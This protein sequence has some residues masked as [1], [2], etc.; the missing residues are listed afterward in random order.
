MS[1]SRSLRSMRSSRCC[2]LLA[3]VLTFVV[4]PHAWSAERQVSFE[5]A[6]HLAVERAPMLRARESQIAATKE[7]AARAAALPDPK[8][9]FGVANLPVTGAD[10]LDLSADFMTMK[11][12]GVMQEFPARAKRRARQ[13]V[14]D[15]VVAQAQALSVVEQLAVRQAVSQAWITL[16]AA[17][18]EVRALQA[19]KGPT[20]AAVRSAKARLAGGTGTAVEAMATQNAALE[21][22]DR[23]DAAEATREAARAGLALWLGE[24]PLSLDLAGSPPELMTLSVDAATLLSS[25]DR[26]APLRLWSAREA[27]AEAEVSSAIAEKRPDW[28]LGVNYGQ[29]GRSPEGAS[30]SDMVMIEFSID[31]PLFAR[32]RQ[33]RGI[34]ARR[35][36]LQAVTAE[37]DDARRRQLE[38]VRMTLAEWQGLR[39]RVMRQETDAL[40]LAGDRSRVALAAYAGGADL[41]PWLEARRD[42]IELHIDY[43]RNLGELGRAW[44]ALAYLLPDEESAP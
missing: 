14:A 42:E 25:I 18:Q 29:R 6:L 19:L 34:S 24:D 37:H 35:A 2:S 40:P 10:A 7:E 30:R 21:L 44:A 13:L 3:L 26:Q 4:A 12:I 27:V 38:S 17:E 23:M 36:D 43:A 8:L 28:S 22:E 5:D 31:L 41:Q 1:Y 11:Q 33:D 15:H 20:A 39:R 32:N 9:K 16:W